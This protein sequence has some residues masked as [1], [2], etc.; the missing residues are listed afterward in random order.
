MKKH[1]IPLRILLRL[2]EMG[3]MITLNDTALLVTLWFNDDARSELGQEVLD[4]N[5]RMSFILN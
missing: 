4:T 1:R 5:S 2:R 3:F